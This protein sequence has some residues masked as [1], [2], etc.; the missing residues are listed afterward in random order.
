MIS[1]SN[2]CKARLRRLLCHLLSWAWALLLI[3]SWCKGTLGRFRIAQFGQFFEKVFLTEICHFWT[4]CSGQYYFG[5][6]YGLPSAGFGRLECH[7]PL[8]LQGEWFSREQGENV[9]TNIE[10]NFVSTYGNCI[11][12]QQTLNDNF[13]IITEKK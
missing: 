1:T 13:T 6:N 4:V 2:Q 7:I 11:T 5:S 10:S 12:M 9:I 3:L 8:T